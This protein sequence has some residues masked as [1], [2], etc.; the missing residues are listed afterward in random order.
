MEGGIS[1][2]L[3]R[4]QASSQVASRDALDAIGWV[5]FGWTSSVFLLIGSYYVLRFRLRGHRQSL[6]IAG[7]AFGPIAFGASVVGLPRTVCLALL[8]CAG[9]FGSVFLL[10]LVDELRRGQLRR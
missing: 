10:H 1:S 6:L 5:G 4:R 7:L 2:Q 8:M 9:V 3:A